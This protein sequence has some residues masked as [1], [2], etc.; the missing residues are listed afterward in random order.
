MT[1]RNHNF[2]HIPHYRTNYGML[3]KF[4]SP[5]H[6]L[7]ITRHILAS[8]IHSISIGAPSQRM[9]KVWLSP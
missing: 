5:F 9:M 4:I 7:A 3:W 8:I 1:R 2:L 6:I